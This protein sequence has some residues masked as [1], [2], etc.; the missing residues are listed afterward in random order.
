[1]ANPK[2]SEAGDEPS[3]EQQ[4]FQD[5][6]Q[7]RQ[8]DAAAGQTFQSDSGEYPHIRPAEEGSEEG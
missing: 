6:E 7:Q 4:K 5:Q 1:M 8:Q 2:S 3:P